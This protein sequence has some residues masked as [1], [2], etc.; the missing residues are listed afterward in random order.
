MQPWIVDNAYWLVFVVLG[1]VIVV[2]TIVVWGLN[3]HD[4]K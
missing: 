3:K 2:S 1:V 4:E